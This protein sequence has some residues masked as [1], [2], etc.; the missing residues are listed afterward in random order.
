MKDKLVLCAAPDMPAQERIIK[1]NPAATREEIINSIVHEVIHAELWSLDE[2]YV[3]SMADSIV[4][5]LRQS[6]A[7]NF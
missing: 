7:V 2:E 4:E 5:A 6:G 3:C 1:I